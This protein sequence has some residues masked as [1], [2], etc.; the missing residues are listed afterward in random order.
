[1][2]GFPKDDNLLLTFCFLFV[3]LRVVLLLDAALQLEHHRTSRIDNLNIVLAS[4]S[5]RL[6]RFAMRTQ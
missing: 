2:T 1:M 5:I 3:I 6:R 4:Q